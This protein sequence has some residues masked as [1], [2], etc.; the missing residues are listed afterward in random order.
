MV[1]ITQIQ[2]S[3]DSFSFKLLFFNKKRKRKRKSNYRDTSC[4][5]Q[6]IKAHPTNCI[7]QGPFLSDRFLLD[8]G[9]FLGI[10]RDPPSNKFKSKPI[11]WDT[12]LC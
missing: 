12:N 10:K 9:P 2:S 6:S 7:A 11:P 8:P 1:V 3:F 4:W 5:R